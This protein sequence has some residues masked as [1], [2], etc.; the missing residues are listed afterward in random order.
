S[1]TWVRPMRSMKVTWMRMCSGPGRER[2]YACSSSR[3]HRVAPLSV[4]SAPG[5]AF[6]A[7]V[8]GGGSLCGVPDGDAHLFEAAGNDIAQG[9]EP[10]HRSLLGGVDDQRAHVVAGR[11][12]VHRQPGAKACAQVGVD[13]VEVMGA[14][15]ACDQLDAL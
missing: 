9:I 4:R 2:Q 14:L 5:L 8:H 15:I 7:V 1:T 13:D 3:R 10:G 6:Q 11:T 12:Q